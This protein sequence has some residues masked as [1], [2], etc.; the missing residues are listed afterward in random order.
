MEL[1]D[2]EYVVNVYFRQVV[3]KYSDYSGK[4]K[5]N[6]CYGCNVRFASQ[7]SVLNFCHALHAERPRQ[8]TTQAVPPG[9]S[10]DLPAELP[11]QLAR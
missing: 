1:L 11:R 4:L 9:R 6:D 7:P 5:K 2:P 8:K 3:A 10:T